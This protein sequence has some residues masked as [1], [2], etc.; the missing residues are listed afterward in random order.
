MHEFRFTIMAY[1]QQENIPVVV[2]INIDIVFEVTDV[3][4]CL[5]PG[6]S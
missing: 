5:L 2:A 4:V 6:S 1:K 3:V